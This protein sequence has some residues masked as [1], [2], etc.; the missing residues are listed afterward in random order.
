MAVVGAQVE[1]NG[2]MSMTAW[3]PLGGGRGRDRDKRHIVGD[4]GRVRGGS[5]VEGWGERP[6]AQ[7]QLRQRRVRGLRRC[8]GHGDGVG[9]RGSAGS[10]DRN[11]DRVCPDIEGDLTPGAVIP[12]ESVHVIATV[13]CET[14]GVAVTVMDATAWA[15]EAVYVGSAGSKAGSVR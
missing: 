5:R 6:R 3:W 15:T 12:S 8:R 9:F 1:S 14:L 11:R 10:G 4:Q 2:V 13:A 7:G